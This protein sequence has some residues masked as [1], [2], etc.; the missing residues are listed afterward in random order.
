MVVL[1]GV[2]KALPAADASRRSSRYRET[3]LWQAANFVSALFN[4]PLVWVS[5]AFA[6]SSLFFV[7]VSSLWADCASALERSSAS[8]REATWS[9]D[10]A[11]RV[12]R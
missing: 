10:R 2:K 11:R 9:L 4:L 12:A 5:W 7:P 6:A 8:S 1:V 3:A